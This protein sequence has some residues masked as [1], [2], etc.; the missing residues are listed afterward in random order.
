LIL[1]T[2][3]MLTRPVDLARDRFPAN[4]LLF[5]VVTIRAQDGRHVLA[6]PTLDVPLVHT[7]LELANAEKSQADPL[8][9]GVGDEE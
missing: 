9:E 2:K 6:I 8:V 5:T 7:A 3:I 4:D 1:P